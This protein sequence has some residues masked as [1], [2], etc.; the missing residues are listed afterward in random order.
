M[1]NMPPRYLMR[2]RVGERPPIDHRR[3][4]VLDRHTFTP[5]AY[6]QVMMLVLKSC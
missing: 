4:T 1:F 2:L 3:W 6:P 5:L